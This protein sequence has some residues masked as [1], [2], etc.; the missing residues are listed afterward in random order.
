[1]AMA[2][3]RDVSTRILSMS[4]DIQNE[5]ITIKV[6]FDCDAP[7]VVMGVSAMLATV[8]VQL[9]KGTK[10]ARPLFDQ[11][12]SV[13]TLLTGIQQQTLTTIVDTMAK[14]H[15]ASAVADFMHGTMRGLEKQ[16]SLLESLTQA[17]GDSSTTIQ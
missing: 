12:F 7:S 17:F 9:S 6:D 2:E 4:A 13:A 1:M 14:T 3:N 8:L 5:Q 10:D 15:D 16:H 11:G